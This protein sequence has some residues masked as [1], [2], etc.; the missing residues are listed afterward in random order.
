VLAA[1]LDWRS[2]YRRLP[3]SYDWSRTH[4]RRRGGEALLRLNRGRWPS[5]SA[6]TAVCGS[7]SAAR[8]AALLEV[9]AE[10]DSQPPSARRPTQTDDWAQTASLCPI[11][12]IDRKIRTSGT[13][14]IP[15]GKKRFQVILL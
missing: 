8:R 7:W 13:V 4:V 11:P 12:E 10:S 2:R 9:R 15:S 5:A 1:M 3:S 6:V 14:S